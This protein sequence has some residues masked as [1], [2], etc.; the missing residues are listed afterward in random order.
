MP[1]YSHSSDPS[2]PT[3]LVVSNPTPA[4]IIAEGIFRNPD[5]VR[6]YAYRAGRLFR[7]GKLTYE[8]AWETLTKA[9]A[10]AGCPEAWATRE[11]YQGFGAAAVYVTEPAELTALEGGAA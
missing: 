8:E 10:D 2:R 3:R 9:A 11:M 7:A 5:A 1:S 6:L 4:Q